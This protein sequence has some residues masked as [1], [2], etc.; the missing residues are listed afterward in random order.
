MPAAPVIIPLQGARDE[1]RRRRRDELPR[2][3]FPELPSAG[4]EP[5]KAIWPECDSPEDGPG[6]C[7]VGAR[8]FVGDCR[9]IVRRFW[10]S[11]APATAT[12]RPACC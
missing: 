1:R 8:A 5:P 11:P 6:V 2:F 4:E 9:P 10:P 12:A 7:R 3:E